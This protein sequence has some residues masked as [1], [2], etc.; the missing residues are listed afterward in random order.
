MSQR[1]PVASK[2]DS[3]RSEM[4]RRD[5]CPLHPWYCLCQLTLVSSGLDCYSYTWN[6]EIQGEDVAWLGWIGVVGL[7]LGLSAGGSTR[8][9]MSPELAPQR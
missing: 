4:N 5:R 9:E 3:I 2:N 6:L 1:V 8:S 7:G